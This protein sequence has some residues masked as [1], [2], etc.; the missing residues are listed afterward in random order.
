M[1]VVVRVGILFLM[2]VSG[3]LAQ[4]LSWMT[5]RWSD[6]E[7]VEV[8]SE[9]R[10]GNLMGYNRHFKG[11]KV[12]FFEHLRIDQTKNGT[13]Y[14]AC[15]LGRSWTA[16]QLTEATE[17]QAVFTNPG[18]DFPQKIHYHREG[19]LLLVTISGKDRES[20]TWEFRLQE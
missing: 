6:G 20:V 19:D 17:E 15:P 11:Q 4:D 14:H 5:G 1:L 7:T 13:V 12:T 2:L 3:C 8:W 16:F 18:H 10:D 9:M